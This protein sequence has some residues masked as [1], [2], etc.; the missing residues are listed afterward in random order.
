MRFVVKA[1]NSCPVKIVLSFA[2]L[3][4][5]TSCGNSSK[6]I[7]STSAGVSG[8]WQMS[9]Q[10]SNPNWRPTAQSGFLLDDNGNLTG[11]MMFNDIA[12]SGVGNVSGNVSGSNVTFTVTP[13]GL[14]M[15]FTGGMSQ[16]DTM[17]G[18]YMI[19]SSGCAGPYS[20]P[21]TGTWT[22]N[23]VTPLSGNIQGTFT[24]NA[25][26]IYAITGQLSQGSNT[27]VS[28]ATLSGTL[29]TTGYC[30]FTTTNLTGAIS[31]TAVV[32][33]LVASD[34]TQIGQVNGTTRL[35]GTSVTGNYRLIGLGPGVGA[36]PP[37]VNGESGTVTFSL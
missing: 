12:C 5:L 29:S 14:N 20:A 13:T 26:V 21:Q 15:Q 25:G 34:G 17:T 36:K 11:S 31:G 23:L 32:L 2:V 7:P 18:S 24:S 10:P 4:L 8:N 19:L 6:N 30:F 22:A 28:A 16:P 33:N 3:L 27:G 35:D 37:C 9:L 1:M